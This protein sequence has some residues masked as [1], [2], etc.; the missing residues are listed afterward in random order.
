[1]D[2]RSVL[3]ANISPQGTLFAE[4]TFHDCVNMS[5][6]RGSVRHPLTVP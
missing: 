1:M 2:N 6:G 3:P 4:N 5:L